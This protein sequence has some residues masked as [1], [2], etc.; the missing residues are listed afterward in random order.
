MNLYK[1]TFLSIIFFFGIVFGQTK[2]ISYNFFIEDCD[3]TISLF[4]GNI[5]EG[6][7]IVIEE[8]DLPDANTKAQLF[9][10]LIVGSRIGFPENSFNEDISCDITLTGLC[11]LDITNLEPDSNDLIKLVYLKIKVTGVN[12]GVHGEFEPYYLE[13][14]NE[15]YFNIPLQNLTTFLNTLNYD[16][17]SFTPYYLNDN[18]E[19]SNEGIRRFVGTEYLSVYAKSFSAFGVGFK[20]KQTDIAEIDGTLV[21]NTYKLEQN[22]PNPFNPSTN[23]NYTLPSNG[24][25]KLVVY[26]SIGEIVSTLVNQNQSAGNYS[27]N[28]DARNLSAGIYYYSLTSGNF[29]QTNK[30][31]LLK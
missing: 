26:N 12:S 11:D 17:N 22:Y 27:I 9:Y 19:T 24:F 3:T 20:V 10:N 25:T 2:K 16:I 23:I 15:Y 21:T 8:Y 28:F 7:E 13:N 4:N 1:L 29:V 18:L 31:I 5:Q 30:M 14:G 6:Q